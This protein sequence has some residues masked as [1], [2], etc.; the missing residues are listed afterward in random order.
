MDGDRVSTQKRW[1]L[2]SCPR[3]NGDLHRD[4]YSERDAIVCL[5]CGAEFYPESLTEGLPILR[6]PEKQMLAGR[7][8]KGRPKG[9][10]REH[11][12]I[13]DAP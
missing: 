7:V 8:R 9:R 5:Q 12:E 1:W 3:C 4:A 2:R 11:S 10:A 6:L 13:E